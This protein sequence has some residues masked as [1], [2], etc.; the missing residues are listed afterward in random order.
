MTSTDHLWHVLLY[1]IDGPTYCNVCQLS[2]SISKIMYDAP[3]SV[4]GKYCAS[5][6]KI[7]WNDSRWRKFTRFRG[8]E[9]SISQAPSCQEF[10]SY[11]TVGNISCGI[12]YLSGDKA[13]ITS[14]VIVD[15]IR[16][17]NRTCKIPLA[18]LHIGKQCDLYAMCQCV[19]QV[20]L[21]AIRYVP[22]G[23]KLRIIPQNKGVEIMEL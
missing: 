4:L 11:N 2:V 22:V 15:E 3:P 7:H 5:Y 8:P 10:T 20:N 18:V 12:L 16:V 17:V 19:L 9:H 13:N 14:G 21:Y 1:Y 23:A 6:M